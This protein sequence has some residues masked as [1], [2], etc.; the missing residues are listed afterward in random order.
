MA[1]ATDAGLDVRRLRADRLH[2]LD[3]GSAPV[4]GIERAHRSS[5][6]PL[7]SKPSLKLPSSVRCVGPKEEIVG[8]PEAGGILGRQYRTPCVYPI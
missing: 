4:A 5:V 8:D 7:L 2:A 6:L 3:G 1:L